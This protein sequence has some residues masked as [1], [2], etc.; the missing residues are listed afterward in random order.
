MRCWD[1]A[2][3]GWPPAVEDDHLLG[4]RLRLASH[5]EISLASPHQPSGAY[6][7]AVS[8]TV[9]TA[10]AVHAADLIQAAQY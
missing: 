7:V 3:L 2:V 1:P 9:T 4:S 6:T 8:T 10:A 5:R